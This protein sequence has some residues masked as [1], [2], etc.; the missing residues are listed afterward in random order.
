MKKGRFIFQPIA[1]DPAELE[2]PEVYSL[3]FANELINSLG[4]AFERAYKE[5]QALWEEDILPSGSGRMRLNIP[6]R[7]CRS[8]GKPILQGRAWVISWNDTPGKKYY[9]YFDAAK[10]YGGRTDPCC[11]IGRD[12][13]RMRDRFYEKHIAKIL[14]SLVDYIGATA[15]IKK[16]WNKNAEG[17]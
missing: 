11:D 8:C 2:I 13:C 4:D 12:Y 6:V 15:E 7:I 10:R 9:E 17:R 16:T 1:N 3:E 5:T 14:K